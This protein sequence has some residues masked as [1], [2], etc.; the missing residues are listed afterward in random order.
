M[1]ERGAWILSNEPE[2]ARGIS[3]LL[4]FPGVQQRVPYS[5]ST[6]YQLMG[7]GKFPKPIR[8]GARAVAWRESDID[9]WIA[10]R[11]EAGQ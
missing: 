3:K 2:V 6:I 1:K 4:R 5:H 10:S 9:E 11:S 8:L 7:Q